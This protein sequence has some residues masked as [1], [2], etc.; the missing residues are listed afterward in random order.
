MAYRAGRWR[1]AKCEW[2]VRCTKIRQNASKR[3]LTGF[4]G[5]AYTY[6]YPATQKPHGGPIRA[7]ADDSAIVRKPRFPVRHRNIHGLPCSDCP[8]FNPGSQLERAGGRAGEA[9][10]PRTWRG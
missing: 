7:I 4:P 10:K 3:P 8:R 5:S 6:A 1:R 9:Q 2:F